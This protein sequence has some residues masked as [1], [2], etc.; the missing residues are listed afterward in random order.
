MTKSQLAET[1]AYGLGDHLNI[2]LKENIKFSLNNWRALIIR[3]DVAVNGMS[4][5]FL[6]KFH[7]DLQKVDKADNCKFSIDCTKILRT[8][9]KIPRPVRLK[10]D[11]LFK[12][13]GDGN[14]K[15][16]TPVEYEE[17][18]FTCFNKYTFREIRYSYINDYI[19]VFNNTKLKYAAFQYIVANP[20]AINTSC[21]TDTCYTDNSDYPCPEDIAQQIILG[22]K[23]GEFKISPV[24]DEVKVDEEH[25]ESQQK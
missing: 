16:W 5:G 6:Q 2:T 4:D 21:T 23:S 17:I 22:I 8:V 20:E 3:R 13:I 18:A 10:S 12:Y 9:N 14:G 15:P 25:K 7:V 11:V 1:I 24:S 19:Y